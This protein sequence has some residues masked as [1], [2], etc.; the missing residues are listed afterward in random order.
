VIL[1]R[2]LLLYWTKPSHWSLQLEDTLPWDWDIENYPALIQAL[3][4]TD[5][6]SLT[7]CLTDF[8]PE[9]SRRDE[10]KNDLRTKDL[11]ELYEERDVVV[12][13][14]PDEFID[15]LLENPHH[16]EEVKALVEWNGDDTN[17][18]YMQRL[19][20]RI[21]RPS[22]DVIRMMGFFYKE[23]YTHA[24][25]I[26]EQFCS[27]TNAIGPLKALGKEAS[28]YVAMDDRKARELLVKELRPHVKHVMYL[29]KPVVH[30]NDPLPEGV[31]SDSF[32]AVVADLFLVSEA[33]HR[34][35]TMQSSF[36]QAA[37]M[38]YVG[39][40]RGD[41]SNSSVT[42]LCDAE[43]YHLSEDVRA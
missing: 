31:F 2:P 38:L 19:L 11:K 29:D 26:R 34:I 14:T 32:V 5:P 20:A 30:S 8:H 27:W 10:Y 35:L 36:S 24:V 43:A 15:M 16:K 4:A 6:S 28:V 18:T 17:R 33:P 40:H 12:I 1:N 39:N 25:H 22:T 9:C 37:Q 7:M 3:D 21:L 13:R 42:W 41:R 23:G